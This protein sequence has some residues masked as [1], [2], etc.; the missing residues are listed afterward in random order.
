MKKLNQNMKFLS[1]GLAAWLCAGFV[2]AQTQ[3]QI[4][5]QL[6]NQ[7]TSVYGKTDDSSE[8]TKIDITKFSSVKKTVAS[9]DS[10]SIPD[11]Q[12]AMSCE[13]YPVT[14]G[15][16]YTLAFSVGSSPVS[17]S[18]PLDS[19]YKLRI[20]NL[21]VINAKGLTFLELKE[22]V[23]KIVQKNYPMGGVQFVLTAPSVFTVAVTGEVVE[24]AEKKV[25]AL[26]RLSS[27]INDSFTD[28]SSLRKI[29]V[30][31]ADGESKDYDLFKSM[32]YGDLSQN[33]FLRPGDRVIVNKLERKV[34][35]EGEIKRPGAYEL[36]PGENLKSLIDLYADGLTPYS[37]LSRIELS[38]VIADVNSAG[39]KIYLDN[40]NYQD[41]F[42]L[43]CYDSVKIS[44]FY[45]LSP[46]IFVEGAVQEIS[47]EDGKNVTSSVTS[48]NNANVSK[49]L[50]LSFSEGEDYAFFIRKNKDILTEVSDL[51]NAYII[52][53]GEK[54]ALNLMPIL[55]DATYY[56][57]VEMKN[58]DTLLIPFKQFFVSVSGAVYLPGRYPY[59]PDRTWDYYIG[60]AGG[61]IKEKNACD[62]IVITDVNGKKHK[63]SEFIQPEMTI[64]AKANSGLYYFNQYAPIITTI[65]SAVSTSI[66]VLAVTGVIN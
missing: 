63:K 36:L 61:F 52:R 60:L 11:A 12:L 33:P 31:S 38:R 58:N 26:V 53:N 27:F 32:R 1:V 51:Q 23:T 45:E 42:E 20:A 15:D 49:K 18:I 28:Y 9:D 5:N 10:D 41:D 3:S 62:A 37:D 7:G 56:A 8:K 13:D 14:A 25:W 59:I 21:G 17:Y 30:Q 66:S 40:K 22:Q 2:F 65:L 19:S 54:I 48:S 29:T 55:Y 4:L 50:S 57:K 35:V 34:A 44:S 24:T 47:D 46:H 6:K 39:E 16:I 43:I 64:E